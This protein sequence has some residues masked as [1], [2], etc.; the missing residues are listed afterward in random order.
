LA[1]RA[2]VFDFGMVLTG[3]PDSSAHAALERMTG[4]SG[5]AF[6]QAYWAD[7]HAYDEGKLTGLEFWKKLCADAGLRFDRA[8]L[9]ELNRWDARMWTTQD[10]AMVRW[11]AQVRERGL[12]TAVLSNM[13]DSVLA[14]I[15]QAF[16]WL[17]DFDALVWSFELGVAKPDPRVYEEVL[18][19]LGTKAQE[20]L[21]L[22][23][24]AANVEAARKLDME[25]LVYS[26]LQQLRA[27]LV[28]RGWDKE[29]PVP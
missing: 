20:T 5:E 29:L 24:K 25:A 23:D 19:R 12:K 1:L 17:R 10:P 26:D 7:R 11:H 9:E 4:L 22:D 28:A 8:K 2:V 18:R 6:E 3:L 27:D 14:S 13:G 15:L 21:F 16:P